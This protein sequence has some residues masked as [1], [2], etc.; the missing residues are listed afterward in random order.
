[1]PSPM[2]EDRHSEEEEEDEYADTQLEEKKDESEE[3]EQLYSD[4]LMEVTPAVTKTSYSEPPKQTDSSPTVA[5][6]NEKKTVPQPVNK[7]RV[8][9]TPLPPPPEEDELDQQ[10]LYFAL[11][12]FEAGDSD[13]LTLNQGDVLH[14]TD[15][16]H[17]SW[18]LAEKNDKTGFV[19]KSYLSP[20]Y[21]L[22]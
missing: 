19:P 22:A 9:K 16:R 6:L 12:D 11:W 1:M 13:E 17:I 5:K 8:F 2:D 3:G 4:C 14:V 20:V 15:S 21:E 10:G 7:T 18:W